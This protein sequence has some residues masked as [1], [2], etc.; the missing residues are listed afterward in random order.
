MK[1]R[2]PAGMTLL[3]VLVV[4][5]AMTIITGVTY[6]TIHDSVRLHVRL[7]SEA[8]QLTDRDRVVEQLTGDFAGLDEVRQATPTHLLLKLRDGTTIEY[9]VAT[10]EIVR[11]A[12]ASRSYHVGPTAL[13]FW[14]SDTR[15]WN[16]APPPTRPVT[17]RLEFAD[18]EIVISQEGR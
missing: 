4:M 15:T 12:T 16:P 9:E 14:N 13:A 11:L 3:E 18:S 2:R 7:Q 10:N 1:T 17:L 5:S 6:E 8:Q